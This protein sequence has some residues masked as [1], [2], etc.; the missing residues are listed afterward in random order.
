MTALFLSGV[1]AL[2]EYGGITSSVST[3]MNTA[4][5][6]RAED[7]LRFAQENIVVI[8]AAVLGII[9]VWWLLTRPAVR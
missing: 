2:A 8:A 6:R 5:L 9:V 3:G 7:V 1:Q 4:V